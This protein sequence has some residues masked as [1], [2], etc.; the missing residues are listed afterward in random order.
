MGANERL[1]F[2]ENARVVVVHVDDVGMSRAANEG[3]LRAFEGLATCGSVMVPCPAFEEI[4]RVA[5]RRSD[6]DLGVPDLEREYES[7]LG[8][9]RDAQARLPTGAVAQTRRVG[10][11]GARGG[12]SRAAGADRPRLDAGIDVTH[13]T[14]TWAR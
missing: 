7:C 12:R 9:R 2:Q 6:L 11:R 1:G 13:S 8:A 5:R 3:A 10:E 14:R 4:A